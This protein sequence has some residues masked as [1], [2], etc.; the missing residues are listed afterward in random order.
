MISVDHGKPASENYVHA[1]VILQVRNQ[2]RNSVEAIAPNACTGV[3]RTANDPVPPAIE[4]PGIACPTLNTGNRTRL[5]WPTRAEANTPTLPKDLTGGKNPAP[6]AP[7]T[8]FAAGGQ[9]NGVIA[10]SGQ[11]LLPLEKSNQ[12]KRGTRL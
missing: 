11:R 9:A 3:G 12:N 4:H 5:Q 2:V 1:G 7:R 6:S 10:T 8:F